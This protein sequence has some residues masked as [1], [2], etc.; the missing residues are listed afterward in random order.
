MRADVRSQ[1]WLANLST[2]ASVIRI[3]G[4]IVSVSVRGT[5]C[6]GNSNPA[7]MLMLRITRFDGID[8][9]AYPIGA[10]DQLLNYTAFGSVLI[11]Q[12]EYRS[13]LS[14]NL[15]TGTGTVR[16]TAASTTRVQGTFEFVGVPVAGVGS[17]DRARVTSGV[18]DIPI[19]P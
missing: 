13:D 8:T 5:P 10:A 17:R 4:R 3:D 1:P 19:Q 7:N 12:R 2:N 11:G 18:F 14:D 9:G 15:G 6:E 16:I